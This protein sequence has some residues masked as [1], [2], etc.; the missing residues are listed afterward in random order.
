MGDDQRERRLEE[1]RKIEKTDPKEL[2]EKS[3]SRMEAYRKQ[4]EQLWKNHGKGI[5]K[6]EKENA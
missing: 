1:M 3:L 6:K 5:E 2:M 4:W